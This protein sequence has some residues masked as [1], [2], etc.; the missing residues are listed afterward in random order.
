M[1]ISSSPS[2]WNTSGTSYTVSTSLAVMTASSSTSQK[3][4]ILDLMPG[5]RKRSV[6]HS[7]MS[8]WIPIA[9]SSFTECWVALVFSSAAA[10]MNG[11]SVRWT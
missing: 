1:T 5:G 9:R 11:T 7:R 6:R 2:R 8:G 3:S 10:C 4:A